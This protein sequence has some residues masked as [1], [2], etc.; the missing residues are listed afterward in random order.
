[1]KKRI[2]FGENSLLVTSDNEIAL[3]ELATVEPRA[4][5]AT[6]LAAVSDS[7]NESCVGKVEFIRPS[8]GAIGVILA[9]RS[10]ETSL[11]EVLCDAVSREFNTDITVSD[12]DAEV[13]V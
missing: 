3:L 7:V 4:E 1:M 11:L 2:K 10:S 6:K 9:V 8:V 5:I 13:T 12:E